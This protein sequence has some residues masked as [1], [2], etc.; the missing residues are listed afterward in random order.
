MLQESGGR[1]L[2]LREHQVMVLRSEIAHRAGVRMMLPRRTIS[3]TLALVD[4]FGA[5]W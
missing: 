4:G 2:S 3:S 1:Q 5:V